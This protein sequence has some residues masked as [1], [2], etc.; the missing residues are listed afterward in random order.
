M[1]VL[2]KYNVLIVGTVF[3]ALIN[4]TLETVFFLVAREQFAQRLCAVAQSYIMQASCRVLIFF[5]FR[6]TSITLYF[7]LN[8]TVYASCPVTVNNIAELLGARS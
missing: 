5:L 3:M 8:A 1:L 6:V 4:V 2:P 7:F